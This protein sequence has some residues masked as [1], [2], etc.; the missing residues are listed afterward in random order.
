MSPPQNALRSSPYAGLAEL[1]A[2]RGHSWLAGMEDAKARTVIACFD[3]VG[4]TRLRHR[5]EADGCDGLVLCRDRPESVKAWTQAY[6]SHR[7]WLDTLEK[8]GERRLN[9]YDMEDLSRLLRGPLLGAT[10]RARL[11]AAFNAALA[12]QSQALKGLG[13]RPSEVDAQISALRVRVVEGKQISSVRSVL[14]GGEPALAALFDGQ[15]KPTGSLSAVSANPGRES[16]RYGER[17]D[18]DPVPP[19]PRTLRVNPVPSPE[20]GLHSDTEARVERA[21]FY[22]GGGYLDETLQAFLASR[23]PSM[24][25]DVLVANRKPPCNWADG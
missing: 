19:G 13:Y 24:E 15:S 5:D 25:V 14:A 4:W 11:L 3:A 9:P 22:Y 20:E 2:H 18:P 8:E 17:P 1:C 7:T 10:P 16:R 21:V 23:D 12:Q 6:L